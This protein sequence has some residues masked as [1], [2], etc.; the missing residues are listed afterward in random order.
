MKVKKFRA[1]IVQ[2]DETSGCGVP[3]PFDPREAFGRARAPVRAA[4]G[5]HTFRTTTFTMCGVHWIPLNKANRTAA[6][7]SA[8]QTVSVEL[9]PDEQPRV[10]EVPRELAAALRKQRGLTARFRALS[11]TRQ[12]EHAQAIESAK[13]P[14]TAARRIE[15]LLRELGGGEHGSMS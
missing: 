12:K 11:Y 13:K 14:E 2:D 7:V 6:G 15:R 9:T 3:L 8:G 4:I 5:G 10:V 1:K